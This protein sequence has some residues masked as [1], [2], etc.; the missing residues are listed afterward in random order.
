MLFQCTSDGGWV[1]ASTIVTPPSPPPDVPGC[2]TEPELGAWCAYVGTKC[3]YPDTCQD[4]PS[5]S[6]A[7][8]TYDCVAS[9]G[10][11]PQVWERSHFY[12]VSCPTQK[13]FNDDWCG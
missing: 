7:T 12:T 1:D 2:E 11:Y 5:G 6:P 8:R 4:R 13:P 9:G 10:K 3:T